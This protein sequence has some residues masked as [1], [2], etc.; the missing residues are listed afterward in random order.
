VYQELGTSTVPAPPFL[1]PSIVQMEELVEK[2]VAAVVGGAVAGHSIESEI[3]HLA[4]E[5]AKHL[6]EIRALFL[7]YRL[8]L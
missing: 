7:D 5:T 2:M 6:A 4:I 3:I 1:E 8:A